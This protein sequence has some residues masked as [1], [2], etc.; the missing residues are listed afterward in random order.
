M[1]TY[2]VRAKRWR[3]GWE[4]HIDGVGVTQSRTLAKADQMVRDYIETLTGIDVSDATV[5]IEPELGGLEKRL[6]KLREQMA[7]AEESQRAARE[8]YHAVAADL[9]KEG[10]SASDTATILGKS[11]GRISQ[12]SKAS[13]KVSR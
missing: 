4:L 10:L 6:V 13:S 5:Q 11:R 8:S 12:I 1:T 7:A 2:I 3:H 9:R